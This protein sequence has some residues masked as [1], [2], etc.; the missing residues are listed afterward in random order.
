M[1][2]LALD[3]RE[4]LYSDLTDL[5]EAYNFGWDMDSDIGEDD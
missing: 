3:E 1:R 4:S 2:A 5:A